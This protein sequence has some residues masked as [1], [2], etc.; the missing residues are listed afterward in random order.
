MAL[1][2]GAA[3]GQGEAEARHLV[4][5]GASVLLTDVLDELGEAVAAGLGDDAVFVHLDVVDPDQW[6]AAVDRALDR[7]GRLDVLVNNAGI[8]VVAPLD[9]IDL[10]EHRR[11]LDV[12]L[13]GVFL[14][15]R[16][17]RQAMADGG[18]GSIVNI[19]S[20]DGLV[21]VRG[22]TSYAA[23]KF[24]VT[25]MTRSAALELGPLGIRVN[26]V[27][28]GV[29]ASPMVHTAPAEIRARLDRLMAMQ[30]IP[31]MGE[32]E[33]VA[34]LVCFLASDE[35]SYVTGAQFVVDGGHIAGPWRES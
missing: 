22:M 32:P 33:E 34:A 18:G 30:P 23:S 28:P 12:N 17:V 3:Q 27:H 9:E 11:I 2:T 29:I 1:V 35:A 20:I 31:R 16:A 5:E 13:D 14:G 7:F 26:S 6:T 8:G 25:G 15:M 10:A 24:A 19:S 21:G 4:A